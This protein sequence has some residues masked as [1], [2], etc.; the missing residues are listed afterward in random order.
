MGDFGEWY[1]SIPLITRYWFTGA[2][3]IPLLGRFGLFNPYLMLLD[4]DL[5]FYKIQVFIPKLKNPIINKVCTFSYG[6]L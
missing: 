3:L 5:F 4:W 1:Y 2:T 6:G